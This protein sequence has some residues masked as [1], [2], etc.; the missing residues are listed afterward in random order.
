MKHI[1]LFLIF[2]PLIVLAE[3]PTPT[4]VPTSTPVSKQ[5]RNAGFGYY[6]IQSRRW[7]CNASYDALKKVKTV[8]IAIGPWKSFGKETRCLRRHMR[9]PRLHFLEIHFINGAGLRNGRLQKNE[10]VYGETI[11]SLNHKLERKDRKLLRKIGIEAGKLGKF[12]DENLN[13]NTQCLFNPV[14]ENDLTY[15]AGKN[16]YAYLRKII[17]SRCKFVWNQNGAKISSVPNSDYTETHGVASSTAPG[18]ITDLDG[19][20]INFKHRKTISTT[21]FIDESEIK[22]YLFS[23]AE[24]LVNYLW[25][26]EFNGVCRGRWVGPED[27]RCFPSRTVFNLVANLVVQSQKL[28]AD[29]PSWT[30]KDNLS[31]KGCKRFEYPFDAIHDGFVW[32]PSDAH[33]GEA[34]VLFPNRFNPNRPFK[35]VYL[36]KKG[37]II[38]N[39][40]H[41]GT[42]TENTNL[43]PRQVWR[44]LKKTAGLPYNVVLH[45]D[46]I[47]YILK[48]PKGRID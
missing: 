16:L 11:Q 42:F 9:N 12:L 36:M 20:D 10:I 35:R 13:L 43:K 1:L 18:V 21:N 7:N 39:L 25:I 30:E 19:T 31:F 38:D 17:P 6:G 40:K 41:T 44:S 45:A 5:M 34:V 46:N 28:P 24:S 14:L 4:P 47:C 26:V 23:R 27:R 37:K 33:N 48:N 32:K 29:F 2:W 8:N 22:N 3:T 15:R